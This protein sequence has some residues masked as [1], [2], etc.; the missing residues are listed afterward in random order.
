MRNEK[1]SQSGRHG[2]PKTWETR[3]AKETTPARWT[4]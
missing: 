2:F 4:H 3:P 1:T